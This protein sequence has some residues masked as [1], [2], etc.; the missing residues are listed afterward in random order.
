M[1]LHALII[2]LV[3]QVV[4]FFFAAV[5]KTDKVTDLSY[6]LTFILASLYFF[7]SPV[8]SIKVVLLVLVFLWA[9]RLGSFLFSRILK[10]NDPRFDGIR[11][12]PVRFAK[13]WLVQGVTIWVLLLPIFYVFDGFFEGYSVLTYVGIVVW[14]VGFALESAAD[15]QKR[16]YKKN[17][18]KNGVWQYSRHP[19]YF[20]E[21]LVWFGIF[22]ICFSV[23]GFFWGILSPLLITFI[24]MF[25][26][27]VPPLEKYL[28]KK[29]KRNRAYQKYKKETN[30]LVPWFKKSK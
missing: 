3:I 30:M 13:F 18:F 16:K 21:M 7:T 10:S 8:T 11:E 5:F 28:D 1:F 14:A 27:G 12:N 22:V 29:Y 24:L 6:S 25:F 26:S 19:N 20:G 15:Y 4:F 17:W 9:I 23:S 2:V